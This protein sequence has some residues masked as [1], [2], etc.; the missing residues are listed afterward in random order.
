MSTSG[1]AL[2]QTRVR[3]EWHNE[4][5]LS[6]PS[7]TS[8]QFWRR[9]SQLD[10]Q[11]DGTHFIWQVFPISSYYFSST[12]VSVF[13]VL[14]SL[15]VVV[16]CSH[17]MSVCLPPIKHFRLFLILQWSWS[18]VDGQELKVQ[19][20]PSAPGRQPYFNFTKNKDNLK[21]FRGGRQTEIRCEQQT[22]TNKQ[23]RHSRWWM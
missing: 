15:F 10:V 22:T 12:I 14:C 19:V 3:K 4:K 6:K 7:R 18:T 8:Q 16:C 13:V 11:L 21:C 1:L 2:T 23:T 5:A 9:H 20:E 17:L